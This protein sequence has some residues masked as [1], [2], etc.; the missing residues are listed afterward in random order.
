MG[1]GS[2]LP[3]CHASPPWWSFTRRGASSWYFAGRWFFQMS[4]G[5]RMCVSAETISYLRAI[6]RSSI[7]SVDVWR[8]AI[9]DAAVSANQARLTAVDRGPIRGAGRVGDQTVA[10]DALRELVDR[11]RRGHLLLGDR[12]RQPAA[13]WVGRV[14]HEL[15]A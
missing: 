11:D 10:V 1:S 13:R 3:N 12:Q 7:G 4:G 2:A 9:A 6:E 15:R 8:K 14:A 5:S